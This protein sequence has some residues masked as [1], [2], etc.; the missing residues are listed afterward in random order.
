MI[1][2]VCFLSSPN[3][4]EFYHLCYYFENNNKEVTTEMPDSWLSLTV[5]LQDN[6]LSSPAE[7]REMSP[8]QIYV[9]ISSAHTKKL[10]SGKVGRLTAT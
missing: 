7:R 2:F 1:L 10:L 8:V 6:C 9:T 3:I 5:F 4:W